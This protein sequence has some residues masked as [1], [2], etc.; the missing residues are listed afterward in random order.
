[1]EPRTL[2]VPFLLFLSLVSTCLTS[3]SPPDYTPLRAA[4]L[5][6]GTYTNPVL[7]YSVAYPTLFTPNDEGGSDVLFRFQRSVPVVVRFADEEQGR[8]R[9][10]WFGNNPVGEIQLAGKPGFR[11]VYNHSDGP[12]SSRTT[13]Y[14]IRHRDRYLALEFRAIDELGPV[15]PRMLESFRLLE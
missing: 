1:M 15:A 10:L 12:F 13:A 4:D 5:E 14:V 8:G 2:T 3:C 11:Y 9:G 6:W 7:G